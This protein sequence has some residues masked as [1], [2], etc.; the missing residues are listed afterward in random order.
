MQAV[1]LAAGRGSR[2][3]ELSRARS[4]AMQPV[5]G[6][7]IIGRIL[8]DLT[9][10][11]LN[12]IVVVTAPDD[13]E[14]QDYL[15]T[16]AWK[17]VSV[18]QVMQ[19]EPLGMADALQQAASLINQDFLLTACDNRVERSELQGM[20]DQW[21]QQ[22]ELEAL[23][24]LLHIPA[25]RVSQS[26]IV[27]LS[28]KRVERIIEK[29]TRDAAPSSTASIPFYCLR[30]A[31]L[32]LLNDVQPSVRGERELQ[33]ALQKLIDRQSLVEGW[34]FS[35]RTVLS[36]P[37]DLLAINVRALERHLPAIDVQSEEIALGVQFFPP[38]RVE[39]DTIIGAGSLIGPNVY[40]E[41][42][43]RVGEDARLANC[44]VLRGGIV[45][46]QQVIRERVIV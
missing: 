46:D 31:F 44:L 21:K 25:A 35:Q 15:H 6:V 8:A 20:L 39:R 26:G 28:G 12:D 45:E 38:V 40:L 34:F 18:Q 33:E 24:G 11:G 41:S 32:S 37:Q 2:L 16:I 27:K 14:L 30:P 13:R 9:V 22:P 29:P 19:A 1:V 7:P 42:G 4:K 5:L 23:L 3:G 36:R 43:A 17:S 10:L